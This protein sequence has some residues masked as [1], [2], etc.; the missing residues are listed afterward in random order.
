MPTSGTPGVISAAASVRSGA[1]LRRFSGVVG[2]AYCTRVVCTIAS[3]GKIRTKSGSVVMSVARAM[4]PKRTV[5]P[6]LS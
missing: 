1:I 6:G 4:S 5:A 3:G 2:L